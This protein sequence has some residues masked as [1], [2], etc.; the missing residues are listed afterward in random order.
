M[1]CVRSLVATFSQTSSLPATCSTSSVSSINPAVFSL[2][3]WQV[4]Q[5]LLRTSL[6][7]TGNGA[8]GAANGACSRMAV[9]CRSKPTATAK[10]AAQTV[11]TLEAGNGRFIF[12][13]GPA[14]FTC[15]RDASPSLE[16]QLFQGDPL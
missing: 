15:L 4:T 2:L 1:S 6:G 8:D 12:I 13:S 3:L 11:M 10:V 5:Y 9:A 7:D 16:P 14:L